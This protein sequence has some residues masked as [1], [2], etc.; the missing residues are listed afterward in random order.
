[1]LKHL[2]PFLRRFPTWM[3]HHLQPGR[4]RITT[5][6]TPVVQSLGTKAA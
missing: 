3:A 6:L 1:M 4:F 5:A 2:H